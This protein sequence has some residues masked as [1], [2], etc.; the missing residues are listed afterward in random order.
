VE[1]GFGVLGQ[2]GRA[3]SRRRHALF[4]TDSLGG[5]IRD[6]AGDGLAG[7][8]LEGSAGAGRFGVGRVLPGWGR[9]LALGGP[10][11]P[12]AWRERA[13]RRRAAGDVA[14][15]RG[16]TGTLRLGAWAGSLPHRTHVG[17]EAGA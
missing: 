12:W 6:G 10:R 9:G 4:R 14:W 11:E 7:T 3:A 5:S 16:G 15:Y 13:A 8:S 2:D 1:V 17:L